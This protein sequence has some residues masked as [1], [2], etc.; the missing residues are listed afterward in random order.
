MTPDEV[1]KRVFGHPGFRTGQR[2]AIDALLGG[3]D[4]QVLLPTGGGKSLCF[5]VPAVVMAAQGRGPMLVVSPLIALMEDQVAA[6]KAVGVDALDGV[7]GVARLWL[8]Q[9]R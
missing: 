3:R 9:R 5:Q 1:V 2:A 4:V 8:P 7:I 6:L